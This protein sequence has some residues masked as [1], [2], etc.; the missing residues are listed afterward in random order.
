MPN[1]IS[2][3]QGLLFLFH[4]GSTLAKLLVFLTQPSEQAFPESLVISLRAWVEDHEGWDDYENGHLF[5]Y[6]IFF[7]GTLR[8]LNVFS[9]GF[10]FLWPCIDHR[11]AFLPQTG[12]IFKSILLFINEVV[13]ISNEESSYFKT[14]F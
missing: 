8:F 12:T 11:P 9:M 7:C 4:F 10:Q 14:L 5:I 6:L 3:L 1:F 2:Q 13:F